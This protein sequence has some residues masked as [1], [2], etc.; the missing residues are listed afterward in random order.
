[1]LL[2]ILQ[3]LLQD[4]QWLLIFKKVVTARLGD[5]DRLTPYQS[6]DHNRTIPTH[7][8]KKRMGKH[9]KPK[10]ERAAMK[11][12]KH[13]PCLETSASPTPS[14]TGSA[15][16][17]NRDTERGIKVC[18]TARF[19]TEEAPKMQMRDQI[20]TCYPHWHIRRKYKTIKRVH[21]FTPGP[22]HDK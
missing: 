21:R 5:S 22:I 12:K 14:N 13:F 8:K 16:S 17:F 1:M 2:L 4:S 15:R 20:T 11:I 3:W 19:C 6:E 10:R 7:R 18:D 9:Q